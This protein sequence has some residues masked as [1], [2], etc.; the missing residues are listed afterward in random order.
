MLNENHVLHVLKHAQTEHLLSP[1]PRMFKDFI[2]LSIL[3]DAQPGFF[4]QSVGSV[5]TNIAALAVQLHMCSD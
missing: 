3:K 4:S 1:P 2:D 5:G